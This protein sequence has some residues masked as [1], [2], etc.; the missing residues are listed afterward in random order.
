[1]TTTHVGSATPPTADHP[2][3]DLPSA[4]HTSDTNTNSTARG[5]QAANPATGQAATANTPAT[6]GPVLPD[7]RTVVVLATARDLDVTT[8]LRGA[9]AAVRSLGRPVRTVLIDTG[10]PTSTA[11]AAHPPTEVEDARTVSAPGLCWGAAVARGLAYAR[12]VRVDTVVLLGPDEPAD[13]PASPRAA[14]FAAAVTELEV[15]KKP[16]VVCSPQARPW[17]QDPLSLHVLRPLCLPSLGIAPLDPAGATLVLSAA[18]VTAALQPQW[19]LDDITG[20]RPHGLSILTAVR[21]AGLSVS[22]TPAR[23]PVADHFRPAKVPSIINPGVFATVLPAALRLGA[24]RAPACRASLPAARL[25]LKGAVAYP[26]P[27]GM[28][29]A[30]AQRCA[31]EARAG[32]AAADTWPDPLVTAWRQARGPRVDLTALAEDLWPPYLRWLTSCYRDAIDVACADPTGV[33]DHCV[34][35]AERAAKDFLDAIVPSF[36]GHTRDGQR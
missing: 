33:V 15:Q 34:A 20:L 35:R 25:P 9:A 18:A 27:P 14:G 2:H 17:W 11:L 1:M 6:A 23:Q 31:D 16:G 4:S 10:S 24:L 21:H 28:L 7:P 22:Q 32:R 36:A 12:D 26:P 3:N 13:N 30:L 8:R 19:G 29:M 5:E